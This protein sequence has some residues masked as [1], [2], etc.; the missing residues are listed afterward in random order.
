M[1][2]IIRNDIVKMIK[3]SFIL[4]FILGFACCED[5]Q[6]IS[7]G[8]W[9]GASLGS[10]HLKNVQNTANA[11]YTYINNTDTKFVINTGDNFYYCGIQNISDPQITE[12]F[13]NIFNQINIPWYNCLGNHDYGFKPEVQ[14]ELNSVIPNWIMDSRYY[15]KKLVYNQTTINLIV[16]DTNPCINDYRGNDK[17]KWD[18]CSNEFPTCSPVEGECFFHSNILEQ[19]CQPQLDWFK[20]VLDIIPSNEWVIVF[21][22]H[23]AEQINAADFQSQ[24]DRPNVHLYLNGHV[25]SLQHYAI[26]GQPKYITSGA[27]S[28]VLHTME[29]F[30]KKFNQFY[31]SRNM[32]SQMESGFTAHK[33]SNNTLTTEFRNTDNKILYSFDVNQKT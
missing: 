17:S 12:D 3:I 5:I 24:L 25:H 31:N 18:P 28:M 30:H 21:G 15:T 27:G 33:I 20:N 19:E 14:I 2:N 8:D 32:W 10:Y 29:K 6:F 11:M 13:T 4:L 1:I 9:G 26:N 7:V 16:L 22:H 23:R